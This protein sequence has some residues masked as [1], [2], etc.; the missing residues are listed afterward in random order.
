MQPLHYSGPERRRYVRT[1]KPIWAAVQIPSH[2]VLGLWTNIFVR[3]I[4][5]GGLYFECSERFTVGAILNFRLQLVAG[6]RVIR[7]TGKILRAE[8]IPNTSQYGMATFFC[9]IEPEDM[10]TINLFATA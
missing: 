3:N 4:G 2:N 9:D 6:S 5:A 8:K 1:D 10:H 7:C